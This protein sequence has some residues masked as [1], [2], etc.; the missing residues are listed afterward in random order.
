ML[1]SSGGAVIDSQGYNITIPQAFQDNGG[2]SL[3][4]TGTGTLTLAGGNSYSGDTIINGGN[5]FTT[6]A[7]TTS[8][9]LT[10]ADNAGFGIGV[11]S[12]GAQYSMQNLTLGNSV[13]SSLGFDMGSFGNP[14]ASQGTIG[15]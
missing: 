9:S 2:G 13:G 14:G 8:G 15:G 6:T 3:T 1:L 4:K 12:G 7:S 10:L 11:L 5:L